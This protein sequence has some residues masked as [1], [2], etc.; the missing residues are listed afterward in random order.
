MRLPAGWLRLLE[1]HWQTG[2]NIGLGVF[3]LVVIGVETH[4]TWRESRMNFVE[5]SFALQNALMIGLILIRRQHVAVDHNLFHQAVALVAFFSG[6][7]FIGQAPTG[8]PM[9]QAASNAVVFASNVLGVLTLVNLGRSF[10]ILIAVRQ[11]KTGWLY[12]VVRH[13]MYA[14]DILL[15]VG[16]LISHFNGFT[17]AMFA[18]STAAYVYRAMLEER[19]LA[20][21]A[22]YRSYM[23]RV[24]YRFLPGIF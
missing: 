12:A 23:R 2:F 21:Q 24:R 1:R 14:T 3:F 5:V 7:A 6:I 18:L 22:E 17:A 11:V 4:K 20:R 13:P 19:F 8:G 16:F 9:A 15:R 10:G